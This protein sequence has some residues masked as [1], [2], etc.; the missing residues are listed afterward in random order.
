MD[1]TPSPRK[2]EVLFLGLL[3]ENFLFGALCPAAVDHPQPLGTSAYHIMRCHLI[4]VFK[5]QKARLL[6]GLPFVLY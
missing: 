5:P 4:L 1:H 6:P 2:I 3:L